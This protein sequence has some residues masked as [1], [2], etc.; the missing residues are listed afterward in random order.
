MKT[1]FIISFGFLLAITISSCKKETKSTI[2][3]AFT[4]DSITHKQ[5]N[6]RLHEAWVNYTTKKSNSEWVELEVDTSVFNL[7]GLYQNQSIFE[8]VKASE[9]ENLKTIIKL[10][11]TFRVDSNN[12][13]TQSDDTLSMTLSNNALIGLNAGVNKNVTE[14]KINFIK[15]AFTSDSSLN[16]I[17]PT[18]SPS[19]RLDT[20]YVK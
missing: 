7:A 19:F 8:A 15:L 1:F 17:P 5:V 3:L 14:N 6:I 2:N 4:S 10:R 12:V 13:I 16:E 11:L 20:F 9:I 18:F